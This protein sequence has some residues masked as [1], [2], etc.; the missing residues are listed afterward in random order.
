MDEIED[1]NWR[2]N[3]SKNFLI[4]LRRCAKCEETQKKFDLPSGGLAAAA[5]EDEDIFTEKIFVKTAEDSEKEKLHRKKKS[6]L[7]VHKTHVVAE[8]QLYNIIIENGN[9]MKKF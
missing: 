3:L 1:F 6:L 9:K 7:S 8:I 5:F 2:L 4:G